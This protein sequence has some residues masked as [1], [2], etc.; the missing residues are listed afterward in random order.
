MKTSNKQL[1]PKPECHSCN[2]EACFIKLH[3]TV[4]S[5]KQLSQAKTTMYIKSG[6]QVLFEGSSVH[7]IYF[8]YDG[9]FKVFKAGPKNDERILRIAK[10]G[11]ILGHRGLGEELF[12]PISATSI[13]DAVLCYLPKEIFFETLKSNAEL[14]FHLSMFY[15]NELRH[16]EHKLFNFTIYDVNQRIAYAL[17]ELAQ[18]HGKAKSGKVI[19][20]LPITRTMLASYAATTYESIIRCL[21]SLSR[22]KVVSFENDDIVIHDMDA[23]KKILT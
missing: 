3:C 9:A 2:N 19:I 22:K 18:S 14:G 5:K 23:L 8:I 11:E 16:A 4:P 13:S 1:V 6:Q 7:G 10:T 20:H 12:Y 15:V 17:Y 21:S